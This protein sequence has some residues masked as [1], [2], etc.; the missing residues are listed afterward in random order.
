MAIA[1][2]IITAVA[3]LTLISS[4][5]RSQANQ[6]SQ[7]ETIMLTTLQSSVA[8]GSEVTIFATVTNVSNHPIEE[9]RSTSG[10]DYSLQLIVRDELQRIL[11]EKPPDQTPCQGKPGC[12][13]MRMNMGNVVG[14]QLAPGKSFRNDFVLTELYD[15]SKPGKYSVQVVR[16]ESASATLKS[17]ILAITVVPQL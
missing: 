8:V 10:V 2:R 6:A 11:A 12:K 15:L 1:S 17:N 5:A 4:V 16:G 14:K 13:I 7:D 9:A 3:L